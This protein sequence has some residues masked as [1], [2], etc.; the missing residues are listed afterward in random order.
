[1]QPTIL[2]NLGFPFGV[3]LLTMKIRLTSARGGYQFYMC[4]LWNPFICTTKSLSFTSWSML[5]RVEY[6]QTVKEH[7]IPRWPRHFIQKN[8]S[9]R[10]G[11]S[12]IRFSFSFCAYELGRRSG[13]RKHQRLPSTLTYELRYLISRGDVQLWYHIKP[14]PG[15]L[16]P[17]WLFLDP[18]PNQ[19]R[20]RKEESGVF[21]P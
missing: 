15:Y 21:N 17:A 18:A 19:I 9:D 3:Y 11:I 6:M 4:V 1:M 8:V 16:L 20:A 2:D 12:Y 14:L 10:P 7:I 5:H 13:Q